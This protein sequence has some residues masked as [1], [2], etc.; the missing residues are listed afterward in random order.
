MLSFGALMPTDGFKHTM[1]CVDGLK[2]NSFHTF[3]HGA[4]FYTD[5][6]SDIEMTTS[7]NEWVNEGTGLSILISL[8]HK[9]PNKLI[10]QS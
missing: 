9:I 7:C 10:N 2:I 4:K 6:P 5:R 3:V 1:Q 8:P